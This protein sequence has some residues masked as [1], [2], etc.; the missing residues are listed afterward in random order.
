MPDSKP[1]ILKNE[2]TNIAILSAS[3]GAG[4]GRSAVNFAYLRRFTDPVK[5]LGL[6]NAQRIYLYKPRPRI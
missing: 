5:L 4:K 1:L 6:H 2:A 3:S